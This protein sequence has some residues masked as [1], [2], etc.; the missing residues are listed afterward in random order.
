M[1]ASFR[2]FYWSRLRNFTGRAS[3]VFGVSFKKF[4]GSQLR[5]GLVKETFGVAFKAFL[6][7]RLRNI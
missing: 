3:G 6:E 1:L 2:K 5:N 7:S 4:L